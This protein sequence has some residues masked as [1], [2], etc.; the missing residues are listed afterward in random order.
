MRYEKSYLFYNGLNPSNFLPLSLLIFIFTFFADKEEALPAVMKF[1]TNFH[2]EVTLS[3]C[4]EFPKFQSMFII[5]CIQF[6]FFA[7]E[8]I[9]SFIF[10]T[11]VA[12]QLDDF[13]LFTAA[14]LLVEISW[15]IYIHQ[16]M[17]FI[18]FCQDRSLFICRYLHAVPETC[19]TQSCLAVFIIVVCS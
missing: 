5:A 9:Q 1:I 14:A 11:V 2:T 18:A 6:Y 10:S 19:F 8:A 13:I 3:C 7:F 16:C 15:V 17:V 12:G 4:L